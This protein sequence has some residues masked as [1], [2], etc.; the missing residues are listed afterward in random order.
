[1]IARSD[2]DGR[3]GTYFF[4]WFW[5]WFWL[6][7]FAMVRSA[8][9]LGWAIGMEG[10]WVV[11][12]WEF[13][14]PVMNC[15]RGKYWWWREELATRE[16]EMNM[17]VVVVRMRHDACACVRFLRRCFFLFYFL[18]LPF[19][20]VLFFFCLNFNVLCFVLEVFFFSPVE[21]K[22]KKCYELIY[23]KAVGVVRE[24]L[25]KGWVGLRVVDCGEVGDGWG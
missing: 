3:L 18:A 23:W 9:G 13:C 4:C 1:M 24:G 12:R 11:G 14:L 6:F 2:R 5:F 19:S 17:A 15:G 21:N 8:G 10:W 22:N 20:C 7:G 25:R 16:R